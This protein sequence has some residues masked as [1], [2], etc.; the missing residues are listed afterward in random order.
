M[1]HYYVV[2]LAN[3]H[4]LHSLPYNSINPHFHPN[5]QFDLLDTAQAC[6]GSIIQEEDAGHLGLIDPIGK[7]CVVDLWAT[8]KS[9][10]LVVIE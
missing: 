6:R 7:W 4:I 5:R 3:K 9:S 10:E 8:A 2:Y 1:R